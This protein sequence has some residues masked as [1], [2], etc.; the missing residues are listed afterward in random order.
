LIV[1]G[2]HVTGLDREKA[3]VLLENSDILTSCASSLGTNSPEN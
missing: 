2:V 3:Q 1:I